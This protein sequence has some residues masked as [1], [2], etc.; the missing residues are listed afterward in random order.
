MS[1]RG[2]QKQATRESVAVSEAKKFSVKKIIIICVAAAV[3]IAAAVTGIFFF[4]KDVQPEQVEA[5]P[6]VEAKENEKYSYSEYKGCR[7]PTEIV[8]VLLQA[9]ADSEAA[10]KNGGVA[11]KVG[12][13][14]ISVAEYSMFY[15]DTFSRFCNSMLN[16]DV[17]PDEYNFSLTPEEQKCAD[18]DK[19][20][21]D[22]LSDRVTDYIQ[23]C[24]Y[25]FDKAITD[26]TA[27]DEDSVDR[28]IE[29]Y[30]RV[31]YYAEDGQSDDEIIAETYG[32]GVTFAMFARN[33]I[34]LAYA[35]MNEMEY[36][37][38]YAREFTQ[39]EL[40]NFRDGENG[41][42]KYFSGAVYPIPY[43]NDEALARAKTIK[44]AEE[45]MAYC[46]EYAEESGMTAAE[47]AYAWTD[48]DTV[49]EKFGGEIS[50]W[51]YSP[52]RKEGDIGVVKGAIYD[53]LVYVEKL[54]HYTVSHDVIIYCNAN[55]DSS[56]T[57]AA[58]KN[59]EETTQIY[60]DWVDG[61]AS[62]EALLK[63]CESATGTSGKATT[64]VGE[65]SSAVQIWI[66][67]PERKYGDYCAYNSSE[68]SYIIFFVK[69]NSDDYDWELNARAT[70]AAEKTEQEY[71]DAS[72]DEYSAS[73][74]ASKIKK[75][76][77][78]AADKIKESSDYMLQ[79]MSGQQ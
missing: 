39:S 7:M 74:S 77:K 52:S 53:C 71:K 18:S 78:N 29:T 56:D 76:R 66:N 32:E 3:V 21:A 61:G 16:G 60:K 57:E 22:E 59:Q 24:Y 47:S 4:G 41:A 30:N 6:T 37:E 62:E 25:Y 14:S 13:M 10:C 67:S 68:G 43:G 72:K 11:L 9:E 79:S 28:L 73:E 69:E 2:K 38:K 12:D 54:P 45:F 42:M 40:E 17:Y 19:I 58:K 44:T 31:L 65:I 51:I 34:V 26:G 36:M 75:A 63:L 33:E 15:F 5:P 20:W 1:S 35:N 70:L 8:Q 46:N 48:Y 55:A 64:R 27:L 49:A 50:D 23:Y